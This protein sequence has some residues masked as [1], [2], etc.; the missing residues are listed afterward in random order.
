MRNICLL[1]LLATSVQ[2]RGFNLGQIFSPDNIL[3]NIQRQR[4]RQPQ[5]VDNIDTQG[6]QAQNVDSIV[7]NHV[8]AQDA[9][10]AELRAEIAR[11]RSFCIQAKAAIREL[12]VK[13]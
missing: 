1:L 4:Q 7:F 12:Q 9:E 2:A 13:R 5:N 8:K 3:Q 11:L 6:L 10:I